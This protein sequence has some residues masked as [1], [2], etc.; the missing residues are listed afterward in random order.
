MH[1]DPSPKERVFIFKMADSAVMIPDTDRPL[2][3]SNGLEAK[4]WMSRIIFP[5]QIILVAELL[6]LG[7]G[8]R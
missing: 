7:R 1:P 2:A 8:D 6:D 5:D 4:R 3:E